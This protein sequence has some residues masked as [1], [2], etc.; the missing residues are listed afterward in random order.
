MTDTCLHE[1][2]QE[3]DIICIDDL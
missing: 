1:A 2:M 3:P